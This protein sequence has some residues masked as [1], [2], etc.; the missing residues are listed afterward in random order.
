MGLIPAGAREI[1]IE[2]VAE[3]ANFLAL[4]SEDPEK[5]FLN[6]GWTIQWNGDYQVAG[7]TF[8][9]A[10]TGNWENL[11]SP[12]PT[13]EPVWIQVPAPGTRAGE[14]GRGLRDPG[15]PPSSPPRPSCG[16]PGAQSGGAR[17]L[18]DGCVGGCRGHVLT[19][20]PAAQLLFQESNPGVRYEYT[21]HREADGPGQVEP[22]EFSWSYG[23][24]TQ[25]TVTCGTGED[26]A[27]RGLGAVGPASTSGSV[28]VGERPRTGALAPGPAASRLE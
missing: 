18:G 27:A 19:P 6:G 11:T 26:G 24:W 12:G 23:P 21:I 1:R 25:C 13:A 28:L 20:S 4:R 16:R 9:Y 5:Y 3:A 15:G 7:T 2:E 17:I 22:P 10:R 8:T 14:Q